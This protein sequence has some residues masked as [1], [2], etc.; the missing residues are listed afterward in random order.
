MLLTLLKRVFVVAM[1]CCIATTVFAEEAAPVYDADSVQSFD[2]QS[3]ARS[4]SSQQERS[5]ATSSLTLGQRLSR[6]EQQINHLQQNDNTSKL[7]DLHNEIQSLRGQVDELTHQVQVLQTQQKAMY[8]DL[9][10]R[11]SKQSANK[12][13]SPPIAMNEDDI[14]TPVLRASSA[15]PKPL[16]QSAASSLP[17]GVTASVAKPDNNQP[18]VAEEQ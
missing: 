1:L 2:G 5:E 9:D 15:T 12:N 10:K 11:I 3:D 18:N 13:S 14:Q 4:A 7:S 16:V 6:V 8:S 17:V